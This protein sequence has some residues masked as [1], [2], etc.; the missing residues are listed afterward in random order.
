MKIDE[1]FEA[2]G[3]LDA[4]IQRMLVSQPSSMT[5]AAARVEAARVAFDAVIREVGRN[6]D[7][8]TSKGSDHVEN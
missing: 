8:P 7:A 1:L 4:S 5:D 2:W 6:R 3:N